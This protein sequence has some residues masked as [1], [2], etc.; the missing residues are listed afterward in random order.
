MY[1]GENAHLYRPRND[2][3]I[4]SVGVMGLQIAVLM[5]WAIFAKAVWAET[6][7]TIFVPHQL[8]LMLYAA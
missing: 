1:G 3:G 4:T 2:A 7:A 6:F 5:E 8:F